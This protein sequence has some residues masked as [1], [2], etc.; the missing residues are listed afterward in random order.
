MS[1]AARDM[2]IPIST[3]VTVSKEWYGDEIDIGDW[4]NFNG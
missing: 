2:N 4:R 3:D 1:D